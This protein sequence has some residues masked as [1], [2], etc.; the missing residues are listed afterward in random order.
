V[1]VI[2]LA[3]VVSAVNEQLVLSYWNGSRNA[4][5]GILVFFDYDFSIMH[6]FRPKL[7]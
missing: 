6:S 3:S 7:Y 4:V 5:S 2:V 1:I